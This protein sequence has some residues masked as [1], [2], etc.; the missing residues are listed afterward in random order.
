MRLLQPSDFG[1][2]CNDAVP[3]DEIVTFG[4]CSCQKLRQQ[5]AACQ[6]FRGRFPV[7]R[8]IDAVQSVSQDCY[9]RKLLCQGGTVGGDVNAIGQSA[10]HEQVGANRSN[11]AY[12]FVAELS[13]ILCGMARAYYAD[14][15]QAIEVGVPFGEK[16]KR[17][18]FALP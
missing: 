10:D 1:H 4:F 2:A 7:G 17:G 12:E 3:A 16:E 8:R 13:A 6:H 9:R 11:V 14:Y 18:I 15:T 5:T